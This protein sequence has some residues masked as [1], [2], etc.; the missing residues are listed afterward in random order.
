MRVLKDVSRIVQVSL[1]WRRLNEPSNHI[2][3]V[4]P[5]SRLKV[6]MMMSLKTLLF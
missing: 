6:P 3:R 5:M 4:V 1:V 2:I